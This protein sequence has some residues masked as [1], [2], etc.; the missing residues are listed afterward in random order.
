MKLCSRPSKVSEEIYTEV[1]TKRKT[2]HGLK[3]IHRTLECE[4][5]EVTSI[6]YFLR[7]HRNI[8]RHFVWSFR[9]VETHTGLESMGYWYTLKCRTLFSEKD[10]Q[11]VESIFGKNIVSRNIFIFN[12]SS[13]WGH[14]LSLWTGIRYKWKTQMFG[15]AYWRE[16][17]SDLTFIE[18][19]LL[20]LAIQGFSYSRMESRHVIPK[21][22][23]C[24]QSENT[25]INGFEL[26]YR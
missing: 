2:I 16:Y 7:R 24:I 19:L 13:W 26:I 11:S 18:A 10:L 25:P 9:G 20:Q 17:S 21:L 4:M 3:Y 1:R 23:V 8:H 22:W 14:V 5:A 6:C 15:A 12:F